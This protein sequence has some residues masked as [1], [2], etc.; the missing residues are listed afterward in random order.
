MF[1][2]T[3]WLLRL[4]FIPATLKRSKRNPF[5]SSAT[6]KLKRHTQAFSLPSQV[7]WIL[8]FFFFLSLTCNK[9]KNPPRATNVI[10][11]AAVGHYEHEQEIVKRILL[12]KGKE[13][14]H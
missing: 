12:L 14:I 1:I 13:R 6:F 3:C 4:K 10:S 11:A 8:S 9:K 5:H 2:L 7:H